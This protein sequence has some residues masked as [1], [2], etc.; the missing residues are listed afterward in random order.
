MKNQKPG[1]TLIE[2][3]VVVVIIGILASLLFP[4]FGRIQE[5]GREVKCASNLK[6]LHQAAMS[7]VLSNSESRLP[8]VTSAQVWIKRDGVWYESGWVTG[9][10]ASYPKDTVSMKSYW[11]EAEGSSGTY[12]IRN[13]SLF[14][15]LGDVGDESVYVC[16]TML[17]VARGALKGEYRNVTRSYGMN[18]ALSNDQ[19]SDIDGP[20]RTILFA[21]QGFAVPTNRC[22][23]KTLTGPDDPI[24]ASS[25]GKDGDRNYRRFHR[26]MD[27]SIDYTVENI[28]ELHGRKPG[29]GTGMANVIF[30]D[31]HVER[32]AH[33]HTRHV[34]EGNWEYGQRVTP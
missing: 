3:L 21:D 10:V 23:S 14:R 8:H 13:G 20:S 26:G 2:L 30:A 6:Q 22:L 33:T 9:W 18:P 7:Y 16:P 29:Q 12:C 15:Y 17:K 19:Y 11:W 31:G 27:G 4:V 32:V 25:M 1:F 34:C 28:G 5:S 24:P